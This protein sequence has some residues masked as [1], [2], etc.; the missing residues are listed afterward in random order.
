M[1]TAKRLL[2]IALLG[3]LLGLDRQSV[4][5]NLPYN[6]T[7]A[8]ISG[9]AMR[10]P[11]S[12]NMTLSFNRGS[13]SGTYNDTSKMHGSPLNAQRNVAVIGVLD[14]EGNVRMHVGPIPVTGKITGKLITGTARYDGIN[15]NFRATPTT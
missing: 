10:G 2:A 13:I 4:A 7:F 12:G 1:I 8:P 3:L 9:G 15:Y 5:R 6:V 11:Y 14:V